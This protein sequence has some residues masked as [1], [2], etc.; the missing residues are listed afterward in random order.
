MANYENKMR[1]K[2]CNII[3]NLEREKYVVTPDKDFTRKRKLDF[4]KIIFM[5]L[6]MKGK[7]TRGE[8]FD[9]FNFDK[10]APTTSAFAQQ[11]AKI[12]PETFE[13]IFNEF[14]KVTKNKA[15]CK[16]YR[17]IAC[18]GSDV[19][20]PRNPNDEKTFC[21]NSE[22]DKGFNKLHI[23]A[24]YDLIGHTYTDL[25]IQNGKEQNEHL[26]LHEMV[27]RAILPKKT[28]IIT[29]RGYEGYNSFAHIIEKGYKFL[30]RVK[31][32]SSTGILSGI[33]LP[34]T[35]TFDIKV[36]L[37]L[38]RKHTT[39]VR[40]DRTICKYLSKQTKFDFLDNI[41]FYN[42][43]FRIVRFP[44]PNTENGKLKYEVVITNLDEKA[45]SVDDLCNLYHLRWGIETSFRQLKYT[46][47][48]SHFHSKKVDFITQ[49]IWASVIMYNF[50]ERIV[51]NTYIS[52]KDTKHIYVTNFSVAVQ[53]CRH[54]LKSFYDKIHIDVQAIISQNLLPIRKGR[55]FNRLLK[56]IDIC[57]FVYRVA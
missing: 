4:A 47:G 51:Q 21:K 13:H 41:D 44:M 42:M 15:S 24:F 23:N 35:E 30:V 34:N 10:N 29:D 53:V 43:P 12:N 19:R 50:C 22:T 26:A 28:I 49:E 14:N 37:K 38:T 39:E 52:K 2:L 18:D 55:H 36:N 20:V 33:K 6:C 56:T 11:R 45:F 31:D 5:L 54:F 7:S 16:G 27:D 25:I 8:I 57:S 40:N 1:K 48:L 32:I 9:Y 17:L 3:I 46:V